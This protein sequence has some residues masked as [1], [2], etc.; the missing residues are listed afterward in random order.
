M[1]K[2]LKYLLN[3]IEL[4]DSPPD[5]TVINE[6]WDKIDALF[7]ISNTIYTSGSGSDAY[8]ITV[9]GVSS[10]ADLLGMVLKFKSTVANTTDCTLNIN[11]YGAYQIRKDVSTAL[12][13]GDILANSVVTVV[14]DG[15]QYQLLEMNGV[16]TKNGSQVLANKTLTAPKLASAG[17][18]ADAN[19][20]EL[21]KAPPTVASAV[22]EITVSNAATGAAPS[23][24]ATGNDTNI[25]FDIKTK[26]TGLFRAWVNGVISFVADAVTGAVNYLTIKANTAG[27]APQIAATGTDTNIDINFIPKGTGR[28]KENGTSVIRQGEDYS[29]NLLINSHFHIWQRGESFLSPNYIYTADRWQVGSTVDTNI[30]AVRQG[31]AFRAEGYNAVGGTNAITDVYQSV[32]DYTKY[33]GKTLTLSANIALDSGVTAQLLVADGVSTYV[34]SLISTSGTSVLTCN[35]SPSATK[36]AVFIRLYRNGLA[37]G[38]GLLI[39]WAKLEQNDHATPFIPRNYAE[40]LAMCQ[41]YY[42]KSDIWYRITNFNTSSVTMTDLITVTFK[43]VKRTSPTVKITYRINGGGNATA[44]M[45]LCGVNAFTDNTAFVVPTNQLFEIIAFE[46]DAE[47]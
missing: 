19:G 4:T 44:F 23:L 33:A 41:R 31:D 21:I 20:N 17:Y 1:L 6:N 26:G 47:L 8:T 11:G 18:I 32:E 37:V 3:K 28:L 40:E 34:G 5:I 38:K 46:A 2:T 7:T 30:K 12:E 14:W 45:S 42:E 13:T 36:L 15:T 24:S 27:N 10:Q 43:Q 25:H 9:S 35:I 16:V 22:N 39:N 29:P